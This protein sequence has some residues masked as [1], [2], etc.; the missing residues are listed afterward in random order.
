MANVRCYSLHLL[1][2]VMVLVS[3]ASR[4]QEKTSLLSRQEQAIQQEQVSVPPFLQSPRILPQ[5]PKV[6]GQL[7]RLQEGSYLFIYRTPGHLKLSDP[8]AF[9]NAAKA[10]RNLL[11][12]QQVS[13]FEDPLRGTIETSETFSMES[14]LKLAREAGATYLLY[15]QIDRP[16]T[17]W[18]KI[19]M[20]CYDLNGKKL[21]EEE[22]AHGGGW[23]SSQS[24]DKVTN[25]LG[26]R[27][28]R[29]V[30]G[31]GLPLIIN[32]GQGK[33]AEHPG[34]SL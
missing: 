20:Q 8:N 26:K 19:Q 14:V 31:P 30:G 16:V 12:E 33:P 25:E 17:K 27:L 29:K 15:A 2:A 22:V 34:G 18:L 13:I 4:A 21:W 3:L 5:F 32:G 11:R 10:V 28:N 1:C 7:P 24:L 6:P 23:N 9:H